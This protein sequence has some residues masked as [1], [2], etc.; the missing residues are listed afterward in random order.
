MLRK[1]TVLFSISFFIAAM[2]FSAVDNSN[3]SSQSDHKISGNVEKINVIDKKIVLKHEG[4]NE[5]K[6]FD[7]N[8]DTRF[9]SKDDKSL[10]VNDLKVGDRVEI[11]T[12]NATSTT[13]KKVHVQ[14]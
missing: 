9:L 5:T 14:S 10:N 2:A 11:T 3:S 13:V 4:K 7:Y 12:E 8:S 6:E 1:L